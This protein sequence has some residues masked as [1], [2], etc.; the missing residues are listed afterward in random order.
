[1]RKNEAIGRKPHVIV[2][3]FEAKLKK[4]LRFHTDRHGAAF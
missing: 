2:Q 1:M 3:L 4:I